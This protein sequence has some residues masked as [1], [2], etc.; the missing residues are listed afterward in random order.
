[1]L[2]VEF[3][4]D[5]LQQVA[6]FLYGEGYFPLA[7]PRSQAKFA[8]LDEAKEKLDRLCDPGRKTVARTHSNITYPLPWDRKKAIEVILKMRQAVLL[9]GTLVMLT[10]PSAAILSFQRQRMNSSRISSGLHALDF[11]LDTTGAMTSHVASD[12]GGKIWRCNIFAHPNVPVTLPALD[13]PG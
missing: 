1:M 5:R 8:L 6:D 10:P 2:L 13:Y 11:A 3:D 12:Q 4:P 7:C 9:D